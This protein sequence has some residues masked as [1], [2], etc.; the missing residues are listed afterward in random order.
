[1]GKHKKRHERK[2][3]R[4][5]SSDSSS[6]GT[7]A[8]QPP[9]NRKKVRCSMARSSAAVPGAGTLQDGRVGNRST[10]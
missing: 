1:M 2:R 9:G 10:T 4:S 6:A 3:A 7:P 5:S 8:P